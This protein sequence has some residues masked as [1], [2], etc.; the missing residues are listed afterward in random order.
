MTARPT[1]AV[2]GGS[3]FVLESLLDTVHEEIPLAADSNL[4]L[5]PGHRGVF[6]IGECGATPLAVQ[7]GRRHLYEGVPYEQA[8]DSIDQLARFGVTD[9]LLTNAA[10]GLQ[11]E[12]RPGELMAVSRVTAWPFRGWEQ[13]A[14]EWT[15]DFILPGCDSVGE[16]AWVHGPSY[17]TRA[18]IATLQAQGAAAVGMSTAPEAD[19][20]MEL[21]LRV[22]AVSCLTNNC[23]SPV[24]LTHDHVVSTARES[25]GR[26][27]GLIRSF[28][29]SGYSRK[30][31]EGA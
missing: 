29:Q 18:E 28:I 14:T 15:M 3:G 2:V 26:L 12:S 11:A 25:S 31:S 17:E 8:V 10:G 7:C 13:R 21:G 9:V 27:C 5:S 22:G 30:S 16:Y 24:K 6:L 1:L 20:C 4:R 19:R 23:Q